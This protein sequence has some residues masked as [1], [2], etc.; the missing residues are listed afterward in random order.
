MSDIFPTSWFDPQ[1]QELVE[2][3]IRNLPISIDDRKQL[4]ISWCEQA[5]VQITAE[6]VGRA[7]GRPAGEV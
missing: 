3:F 7:T 6:K 4:L 5:G 2:D 1:Y